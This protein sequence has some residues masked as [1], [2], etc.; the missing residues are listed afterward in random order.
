MI[1]AVII[2]LL[3]AATPATANH[4]LPSE[5]SSQI[6]RQ[7]TA[8]QQRQ[9]NT[10]AP[11]SIGGG[12]AAASVSPASQLQRQASSVAAGM[13]NHSEME[14]V[15]NSSETVS[16]SPAAYS[17]KFKFTPSAPSVQIIRDSPTDQSNK[18]A[19][20]T[21][22][23]TPPTANGT[24]NQDM[25]VVVATQTS[26]EP[27]D[28]QAPQ[29]RQ[30]YSSSRLLLRFVVISLLVLVSLSLVTVYTIKFC[31][32]NQ[33]SN[34]G[35]SAPSSRQNR[36]HHHHPHGRRPKRGPPTSRAGGLG[37]F[38]Q[39]AINGLRRSC[40]L[41]ADSSPTLLRQHQILSDPSHD[42]LAALA[43]QILPLRRPPL[44]QQ[45]SCF[46]PDNYPSASNS[47]NFTQQQQQPRD[48]VWWSD[49][50]P[51]DNPFLGLQQQP[52][53]NYEQ[54]QQQQQ[55]ISADVLLDESLSSQQPPPP[56]YAD[57]Y[58][59]TATNNHQPAAAVSTID[60]NQGQQNRQKNL[61]VKL[62]LNKT[63][64][65]SPDELM[66]L[67][68]LIDV[69][70]VVQQQQQQQPDRMIATD[71]VCSIREEPDDDE[72]DEGQEEA[73]RDAVGS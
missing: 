54:Q 58:S 62:N 42:Q 5:T 8:S 26:D 68:R 16:G 59:T 65:L 27:P 21:S 32:C 73:S 57:I 6:Q 64:V 3:I 30:Q 61:L 66:L 63:R 60:C 23:P 45:C 46:H 31:L 69:P 33:R 29:Q 50:G 41:I 20:Q 12:P 43:D 72:D 55:S 10:T 11:D 9:G 19:S 51:N 36:H 38:L 7:T 15:I 37:S 52:S 13:M 67:S 4:G 14:A 70:I 18:S 49:S 2:C 34:T 44:Q 40:N 48:C 53:I 71:R 39:D 24:D 56:A 25:V 47:E 28:I 1:A 22:S 17:E 35:N